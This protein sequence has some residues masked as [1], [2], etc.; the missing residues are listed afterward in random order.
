MSANSPSSNAPSPKSAADGLV[1][2]IRRS[3]LVD[4]QQLAKAIQGPDEPQSDSGVICSRLIN[5][6]LLTPWQSEQLLAGRYRGFFLGK[7]KMLDK[8]GS[9]GMS[10]VYLAEHLEMGRRVAIKVLTGRMAERPEYLDRFK[11]EARA[12]ARVDHPNIVRAYDVGH[13]G[14][15]HFLVMEY[16]QG[17]DLQRMVTERGPLSFRAAADYARQAALG[18][19]HVHR[20]ELIHRDIKPANFLVDEQGVLKIVDL[21]LARVAEETQAS[22]SEDGEEQILGTA[23]Y[24]APEQSFDSHNVCARTDLYSLGCSLYFMLTGRAPFPEGTMIERIRAHRSREPQNLFELRPDIPPALAA[25]CQKLMAK[26]PDDRFQSADE[27]AEV[28]QSWLD[29]KASRMLGMMA[30]RPTQVPSAPSRPASSSD[31]DEELSLAPIEEEKPKSPSSIGKGQAVSEKPQSSPKLVDN[32]AKPRPPSTT[33]EKSPSK[34]TSNVTPVEELPIAEVLPDELATL[35]DL[36]E[37]LSTTTPVD[38][39][40]IASGSLAAG[41]SLRPLGTSRSSAPTDSFPLWL[42]ATA[43]VV[44]VGVVG[45]LGWILYTA[46]SK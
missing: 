13:D 39:G 2:L 40:P 26:S 3:G 29:G 25:I 46:F 41:P 24:L 11:Y 1:E 22:L 36:L 30:V 6:G 45:L 43:G 34:P 12:A 15:I 19:G 23:D 28:L 8:L 32:K 9:G 10:S 18:L 4:D 7:Y 16:I 14:N 35:G 33:A 5:A 42:L 31:D 20:A 17:I 27:V 44:I 21:G 37:E 38:A